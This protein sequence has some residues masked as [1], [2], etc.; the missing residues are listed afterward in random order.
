[1]NELSRHPHLAT[2]DESL[3]SDVSWVCLLMRCPPP[4]RKCE[5]HYTRCNISVFFAQS[6]LGHLARAHD[7]GL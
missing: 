5:V 6:C 1:M 7:K 4:P 2:P 3:E